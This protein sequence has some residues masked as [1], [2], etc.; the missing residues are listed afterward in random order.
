MGKTLQTICFKIN[1]YRGARSNEVNDS[2]Q[3][4]YRIFGLHTVGLNAVVSF[5][6]VVNNILF[7]LHSRSE[8]NYCHRGHVIHKGFQK[9]NA[10][11]GLLSES[12]PPSRYR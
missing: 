9:I 4:K 3:N 10:M 5:R 12:I 6:L 7:V 1:D 8:N 2:F 11:S